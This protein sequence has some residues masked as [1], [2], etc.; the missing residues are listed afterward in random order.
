M[1]ALEGS[2]GLGRHTVGL[3]IEGVLLR[4]L[5]RHGPEGAR[6][7]VEGEKGDLDPALADRGQG[8]IGEMERRGGCRDRP[9][10][11]REDRLVA[12]AVLGLVWALDVGRKGNVPHAREPGF[13][14]WRLARGYPGRSSGRAEG[15]MAHASISPSQHLSLEA[16]IHE[17][18][19]DAGLER[20]CRL[21]E[22]GPDLLLGRRRLAAQEKDLD[23]TRLRTAALSPTLPGNHREQPRRQHPGVVGHEKVAGPEQ[24]RQLMEA[25]VRDRARGAI[26]RHQ[27]RAVPLGRRMLRDP[28]LGKVE[29]EIGCAETTFLAQRGS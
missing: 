3:G 25:M 22:R 23:F 27:S 11:A 26:Q 19:P 15:D 16:G 13:E 4:V 10:I 12:L 14:R 9:G 1:G 17:G 21:R 29:M 5:G 7:H 28:V 6:T 18:E 20:L 8:G 2:G 24:R